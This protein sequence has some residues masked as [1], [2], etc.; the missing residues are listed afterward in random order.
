MVCK[1]G[2]EEATYI[3]DDS[4]EMI[5]TIEKLM[6]QEFTERELN[7]R[8]EILGKQFDNSANTADLIQEIYKNSES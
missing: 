6:F 8:R 4:T 1:S 7:K 2:M 5:Q 3:S